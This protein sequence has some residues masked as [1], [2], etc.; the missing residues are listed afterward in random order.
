MKRAFTC[1]ICSALAF[2]LVG[3]VDQDGLSVQPMASYLDGSYNLQQESCGKS[4]SET[5]LTINGRDFRFYESQCRAV[6]VENKDGVVDATLSCR[7][8]GESFT[9]Q[10]RL[11]EVVG[12]IHL[13]ESGLM[14]HYFRC[15]QTG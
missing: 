7:G 3:C 6:S 4:G 5:V 15:N 10:V 2:V 13:E 1:G 12:A 8:E 9:R 11:S 14:R